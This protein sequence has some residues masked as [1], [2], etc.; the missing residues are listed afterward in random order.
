MKPA[1]LVFAAVIFVAGFFA[2]L[3]I[4]PLGGVIV[5]MALMKQLLGDSSADDGERGTIESLAI[6]IG[7]MAGTWGLFIVLPDAIVF[8]L[9]CLCAIAAV[10]HKIASA[11]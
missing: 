8:G 3:T 10:V 6:I 9:L 4:G 5:R 1:L 7:V 11:R 2:M